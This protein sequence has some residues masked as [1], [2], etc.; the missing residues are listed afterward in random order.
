MTSDADLRYAFECP[1]CA[2]SFSITLAKI[3]PAQARFSC[4]RCGKGMDFPSRD[5]A[6]VYMLLQSGEGAPNPEPEAE[7]AAPAA[8]PIA[9]PPP[10]EP[11][12]LP[13]RSTP[14][15]VAAVA[16]ADPP[17]APDAEK[18]YAVDK[19][20]FEN[21]SYDRRSIRTLIRT[22]ALNEV[23]PVRLGDAPPVRAADLADLKSLFELRKTARF[24]PPPVCRKHTDVLAHYRCGATARPL[25]DDCAPE[26][27]FG[28][29]VVRVCE[30][31]GGNAGNLHAAPGDLS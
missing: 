8:P 13:P 18:R 28:G 11:A 4:P 15:L 17:A 14:A 30:H 3:P 10:P 21:D 7:R 23:D 5:E 9:P 27:K 20:G 24:T 2:A 1:S 22:G 19:P 29:T 16:K 25:C 31:C 26:K 12:A 6:R